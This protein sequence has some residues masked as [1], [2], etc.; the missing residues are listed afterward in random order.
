MGFTKAKLDSFYKKYPEVEGDYDRL[1][2][3]LGWASQEISKNQVRE[4]QEVKL[5]DGI[6][7]FAQGE[8]Q[9]KLAKKDDPFWLQF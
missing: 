5:G 3:L 9:E 1:A 4:M 8:K 6:L 7:Y 2:Y